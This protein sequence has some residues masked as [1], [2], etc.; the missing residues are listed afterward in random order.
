MPHHLRRATNWW[1]GP[2]SPLWVVCINARLAL[3][4]S[5]W[6]WMGRD[7][8]V[9]IKLALDGPRWHSH[10][11]GSRAILTVS[12]VDCALQAAGQAQLTSNLSER[13]ANWFH[14]QLLLSNAS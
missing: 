4:G 2:G 6:L 5:S 13:R 9:R 12:V 1:D 7:G 11:G 14:L 10:L 8:F 3:D